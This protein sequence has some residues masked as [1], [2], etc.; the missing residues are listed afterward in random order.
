MDKLPE[1]EFANDKH[2]PRL[3]LGVSDYIQEKE[4]NRHIIFGALA[5]GSIFRYWR[6]ITFYKKN[7]GMFLFVIVPSFLFSA[8]QA[9]RFWTHD[10][11]AYAAQLNNENEAK[12]QEEY[13]NLWR[14]AK[15][16]NIEIPDHLIK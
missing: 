7:N 16:K 8:Y 2:W 4:K 15:R 10:A 3:L 13:R 5:A 1:P 14:E 9:A 12:Y 6:E 11:H